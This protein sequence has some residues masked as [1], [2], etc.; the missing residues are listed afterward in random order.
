LRSGVSGDEQIELRLMV[1]QLEFIERSLRAIR[2][3]GV[4]EPQVEV[5]D[6]TLQ[7]VAVALAQTGG[8]ERR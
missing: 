7:L 1:R 6:D 5:L 4:P 8:S 2:I 3:I